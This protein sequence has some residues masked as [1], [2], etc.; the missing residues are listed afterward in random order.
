MLVGSPDPTGLKFLPGQGTWQAQKAYIDS[1]W[2]LAF[3][4]IKKSEPAEAA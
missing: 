1:F 2:T 4:E 3:L